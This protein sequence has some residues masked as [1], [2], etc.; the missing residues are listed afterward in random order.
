MHVCALCSRVCTR[1]II[2]MLTFLS[3]VNGFT[4][5]SWIPSAS[6]SVLEQI[7]SKERERREKERDQ[8]NT[9]GS[10]E[11][12]GRESHVGGSE[13]KLQAQVLQTCPWG[14]N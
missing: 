10:C 11:G 7:T 5:V 2:S 13:L 6:S 9:T 14:I 12:G 8:R 1:A 4:L 3:S